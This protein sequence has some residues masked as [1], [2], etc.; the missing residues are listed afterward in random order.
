MVSAYLA[1][2]PEIGFGRLPAYAPEL[3]P[4]EQVWNQAKDGRLCNYAPQD[5]QE[6][7][8]TLQQE[9]VRLKHRQD[10]LAGCIAYTGLSV[11]A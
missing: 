10:L 8:A 3:N 7:R 9:L 1:D 4:E 2:H 6:L 11:A 5:I